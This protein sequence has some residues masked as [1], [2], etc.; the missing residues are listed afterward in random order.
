[1]AQTAMILVVEDKESEREA[2]SRLLRMEKYGIVAVSSP[3]EA[4]EHL[5][6]TIDLVVSDLKMGKTS[7]VDL[8]RYW[9]SRRPRTPFIMVT[10]HG[11]VDSAVE[12]MKLGAEDYLSKPV[13][14]DE[15]LMLVAKC[16]EASRKDEI[17]AELTQRL[18]ER[19]GFEKI[20]GQS[21]AILTVFENA[22][23]AAMA[24]STVLITGESGTGKELIAEAIHQN[25]P[26]K[27]KPFVTVNMA[28][29][30]E[31]LVESELFGHVKGAF[32]GATE[33]RIGRFEAANDGTLFIDEIGDFKLESQ[34]K[35]LR[36]LEN[37][38]VTAIGSN[39][40]REVN[41]RVVA[42]TSRNL[43]QMVKDEEFREDLYYRLN[44]VNL[45]LPPLRHRHEDIPLLVA[46]FLQQLSQQ[47]DRAV[48][49]LSP[50]LKEYLERHAWPGNVRQLRNCLE[51]MV[52]LTRGD[53]LTMDD[54][55]AI[56]ENNVVHS[57]HVEIPEGTKLE[58][59]EHEAVVQA[60][61][62]HDGNRTHAAK[63]LGISV[64]TLQR[65][66][67]AWGINE[68]E[69]EEANATS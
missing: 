45:R 41:V 14:P 43:D 28:A 22:R 24:A 60:L 27:G 50:P 25:S 12:A 44:V 55:P 21:K 53:T 4:I 11:D 65:K 32:T 61:E 58:E 63:S 19:L 17:I 30:P 67:K 13:N 18:D 39:D 5:D 37:Q 7:G 31:H 59:L 51:S 26:R 52:V 48:P 10:A 40:D 56:V 64:R 6:Q 2:L 34:A 29:V 1:M 9:K 36:V 38:T 49:T 20:V 62:R 69:G 57:D 68:E 15:L 66:L 33:S 54:L 23:R 8:L 46:H 35:L 16:L 47:C 3:K 42:A